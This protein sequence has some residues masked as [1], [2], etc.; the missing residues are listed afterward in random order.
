ML[1][2]G[3]ADPAVGS[4]V[5]VTVGTADRAPDVARVIQGLFAAHPGLKAVVVVADGT[6]LGTATPASIAA[7]RLAAAD[8]GAA[9]RARLS[10][11]PTEF[12]RIVYYCAQ[13][14]AETT[15]VMHDPRTVPECTDTA[16]AHGPMALRP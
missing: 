7:A 12:K 13:C 8:L 5:R 15:R 14:G 16:P 3:E 9:D 4:E 1:L 11:K 6:V 2:D 10:G